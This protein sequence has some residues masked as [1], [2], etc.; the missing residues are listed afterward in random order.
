MRALAPAL[1]LSL[2]CACGPAYDLGGD[3][4]G[5]LTCGSS[6]ELVLN[7]TLEPTDVDLRWAGAHR[8]QFEDSDGNAVDITFTLEYTLVDPPRGADTLTPE[9]DVQDCAEAS[10]GELNCWSASATWDVEDDELAGALS[11]FIVNDG[12]CDYVQER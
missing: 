5:S 2:L 1:L 9:V 10:F 8:V 11:G 12:E 6:P 3:W 7:T 4:T